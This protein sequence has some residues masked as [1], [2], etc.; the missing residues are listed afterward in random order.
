MGRAAVVIGKVIR[1]SGAG[2]VEFIV[3]PSDMKFYFLEVN[4]R[5]QVEHPVTEMVLQMD[6]VALQIQIARGFSLP[7]LALN[8]SP[9]PHGHSIQCRLYAETPANDFLPSIGTVLLWKPFEIDGVR[10]DSGIVSGV[11]LMAKEQRFSFFLS[12]LYYVSTHALLRQ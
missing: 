1:Y 8:E 10:Y 11:W 12:F 3:T 5:L 9:T 7:E 6:L 4:T 2:T